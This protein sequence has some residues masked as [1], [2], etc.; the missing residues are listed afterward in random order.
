MRPGAYTCTDSFLGDPR[1]R[2]NRQHI[3]IAAL[4]G[5]LLAIGIVAVFTVVSVFRT[6]EAPR[7]AVPPVSPSTGRET[8]PKADAI[9]SQ[10]KPGMLRVDVEALLGPPMIVDSIRSGNGKLSYRATFSRDRL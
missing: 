3:R 7:I 5:L 1:M 10:L 2:L 8:Q 6:E 9:L 4:V